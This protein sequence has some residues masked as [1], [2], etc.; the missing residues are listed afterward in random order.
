M[1]STKA[2][3]FTDALLYIVCGALLAVPAMNENLWFIGWLAPIPVFYREIINIKKPEKF[4]RRAYGRGMLFFYAYGLVIF[5][6]F[7]A[8]YP[9]DFAGFSK[10]AALVV[11]LVAWLGLPLLQAFVSSFV[12]VI[13]GVLLRKC[14]LTKRIYPLAAASLWVVFEWIQTQTWAG[15]PWGKLALGQTGCLQMIQSASLFGPYFVS[16]LMILFS[17]SL[18]TAF[19][20]TLKNGIGSWK[21]L[22]CIIGAV[23]IFFS[24]A[25]FGIIRYG[26][27]NKYTEGEAITVAA[28]QG[29]VSS[30][31]KWA[32][33]SLKNMLGVYEA[34]TKDAADD[35]AKLIV[36]PE[37]VLPYVFNDNVKLESFMTELAEETD[38]DILTGAFLQDGDKLYNS[39][40]LVTS[41]GNVA[42]NVYSKQR[43]VPFG[44][45]VP[46]RGLFMALIPQLT[47]V[48][49]LDDDVAAG[50]ST[51]LHET[52]YG[53]VAS[54]VCFDSIYESLA[55]KQVKD[56]ANLICVST[57]DSWFSDSPAVY[58][59]NRHSILRAVENARYVVRS[60]NTGISSVI[61]PTGHVTK[62]LDPLTD[63]YITEDVY[64]LNEITLYTAVGNIIVPVCAV[65]VVLFGLMS[66]FGR[67]REKEVLV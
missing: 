47:E 17:A 39:V 63:G 37:T 65:I 58:Q 4:I 36:Y 11:V 52:Q 67:K 7:P 64:M 22:S 35:G 56:G 23:I 60:A 45:F 10:G 55:R 3:A 42:N 40:F 24:N 33:N 66:Y 9:L 8:L 43:L 46:W 59:H 27:F 54:L 30:K 18:A 44:E 32:D 28:I 1:K 53:K 12:F 61:T 31:D 29:N 25:L 2:R 41:D 16:F 20:Y 51:A 6:W 21:S 57:N 15:V 50:N 19:Y 14:H 5:S 38:T 13:L 49:M 26:N 48:P 62:Y 34:Y